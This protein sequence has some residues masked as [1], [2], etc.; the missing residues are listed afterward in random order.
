MGG[1]KPGKKRG[2]LAFLTTLS[3]IAIKRIAI[4]V[5]SVLAVM[6]AYK[7]VVPIALNILTSDKVS[8]QQ[9]VPDASSLF[10]AEGELFLDVSD[11]DKAIAISEEVLG[12]ENTKIGTDAIV[13]IAETIKGREED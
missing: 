5:V 12:E 7:F 8:L 1:A 10:E 4:V 2:L 6:F 13:D 9:V 3:K 11:I